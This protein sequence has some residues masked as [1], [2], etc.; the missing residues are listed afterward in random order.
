[1][2]EKTSVVIGRVKVFRCFFLT[3]QGSGSACRSIYGGFVTWEKGV[4]A[5]GT[6]S[7]AVQVLSAKKLPVNCTL[8]IPICYKNLVF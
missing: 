8:P 2:P 1:M 3:R 6:D 4:M 5:D 7:I